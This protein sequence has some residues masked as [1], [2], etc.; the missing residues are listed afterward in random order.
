MFVSAPPAPLFDWLKI[1]KNNENEWELVLFKGDNLLLLFLINHSTA[2]LDE[3][4][5]QNDDR[6]QRALE[7]IPEPILADRNHFSTYVLV[8]FCNY[9]IHHITVP[10]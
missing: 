3:P 6:G 2:Q 4:A 10:M 9:I 5:N 8:N 1:Q 7:T